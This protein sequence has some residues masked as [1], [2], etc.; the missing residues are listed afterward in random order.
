[1]AT[2]DS[3]DAVSNQPDHEH[4]YSAEL[5]RLVEQYRERGVDLCRVPV[6]LLCSSPNHVS[7]SYGSNT[8]FANLA[9]GFI[10]EW[11]GEEWNWSPLRPYYQP[12]NEDEAFLHWYCVSIHTYFQPAKGV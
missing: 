11:S 5:S 7:T 2:P 8:S 3:P 12:L 9:K 10:E 6:D 1:M 4:G